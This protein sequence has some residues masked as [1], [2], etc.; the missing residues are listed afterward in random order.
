MA[1]MLVPSRSLGPLL[2][3]RSL[4]FSLDS[5]AQAGSWLDRAA[6]L[7]AGGAVGRRG[8]ATVGP[9]PLGPALALQAARQGLLT[10]LFLP[11]D[12]P[13]TPDV[14]WA[15]ACG[16]RLVRVAGDEATLRATLAERAPA[17]DL[18]YV[19]PN[20]P[21][22]GAALDGAFAEVERELAGA[23]LDVLA[24]PILLGSESGWLADGE[25]RWAGLVVA[26]SLAPHRAIAGPHPP[27]PSLPQAGEGGDTSP[28]P[29]QWGGGRGVGSARGLGGGGYSIS[30]SIRQAD[31]AR[32]LLARE[33][34]LLASRRGV[35]GL[36][37]LMRVR[38]DKS[39][40]K[41]A[42]AVVALANDI[43]GS[44]D[45]P[46]LALE[47]DLLGEPLTLDALRDDARG[48]LFRPPG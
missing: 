28:S 32:R 13:G 37:A 38:R 21:R 34:G 24:V 9:T 17:A 23:P 14:Q 16:A 6:A 29:S 2:G 10:L 8:L 15:V 7:I 41:Q 19:D 48:V 27:S 20:D 1:G 25:T 35:A 46:P 47:E 31:A 12:A 39:F 18:E 26:G 36:A 11:A 43:G 42:S 33:E 45:G 5:Q 4:W 22:L 44:G 40:P 3:L 30:V